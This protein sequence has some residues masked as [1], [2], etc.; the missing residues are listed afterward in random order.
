[1][2]Q[3]SHVSWKKVEYTW[4]LLVW[5]KSRIKR[6]KSDISW[7][8]FTAIHYAKLVFI[9]ISIW[10]RVLGKNLKMILKRLGPLSFSEH[11]E[12]SRTSVLQICM[13]YFLLQRVTGQN[14]KC[15]A[16]FLC[17]PR[18]DDV[19]VCRRRHC[20]SSSPSSGSSLWAPQGAVQWPQCGLSAAWACPGERWRF[21]VKLWEGTAA[22]RDAHWQ[23]SAD[24]QP[25]SGSMSRSGETRKVDAWWTV[26]L[27]Q[28]Q[29]LH[30][31]ATLLLR[32]QNTSHMLEWTPL[33]LGQNMKSSPQSLCL[34][35]RD[36]P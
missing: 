11:A 14:Q 33:K 9:I 28:A 21:G 4:L 31:S 1:M 15:V 29:V 23:A 26:L 35:P 7:R 32:L 6:K 2:L 5:W 13:C 10:I 8:I 27:P 24:T 25:G 36:Q 30:I 16:S 19:T 20:S 3:N 34:M 18:E 22:E 12:L 17:E